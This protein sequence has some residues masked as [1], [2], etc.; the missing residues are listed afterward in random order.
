MRR[1]AR[2]RSRRG[3]AKAE[4]GP[5]VGHIVAATVVVISAVGPQAFTMDNAVP[6]S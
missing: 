3:S 2:R 4:F 1:S 6:S 5:V